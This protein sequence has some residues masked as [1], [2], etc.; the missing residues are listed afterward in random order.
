MLENVGK[1]R[2]QKIYKNPE[3]SENNTTL[4]KVPENHRKCMKMFENCRKLM[5]I[6]ENGKKWRKKEHLKMSENAGKHLTIL[7]NPGTLFKILEE[8][9]KCWGVPENVEE[10]QKKLLLHLQEQWEKRFVSWC[11]AW[12]K[13]HQ[14]YHHTRIACSCDS[15]ST[16]HDPDRSRQA[17]CKQVAT[18]C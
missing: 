4:R 10:C 6:L 3:R 18:G 15:T 1:C 14:G 5:K 16:V 11:S 2:C 12:A 13:H 17:H 7:E 9:W 8:V